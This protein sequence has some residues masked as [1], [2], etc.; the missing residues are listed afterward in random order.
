MLEEVEIFRVRVTH[1]GSV[2]KEEWITNGDD[3]HRC[4]GPA[5]SERDAATGVVTH[6]RWYRMNALHRGI[7]PTDLYSLN[8]PAWID[9]PA[10]I[11]RDAATGIVTC[12][13]WYF[14]KKLHRLDGPAWIERDAA[15]GV[16]TLEAWFRNGVSHRTGGPAT[17]GWNAKS[18]RMNFTR[19]AMDGEPVPANH[20]IRRRSRNMAPRIGAIPCVPV[21]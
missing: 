11:E 21:G 17:I 18:G 1:T 20:P 2:I 7:S 14:D 6:E 5:I 13:R 9:G 12:E 15:T 10:W 4:N 16:I 8:N 3:L 19:W